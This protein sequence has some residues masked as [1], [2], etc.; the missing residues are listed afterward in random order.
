MFVEVSVNV[1]VNGAVPEMGVPV[2]EAIG[3]IV[4]EMTVNPL[5]SVPVWVSGLVTTTFHC[6]RVFPVKSNV[7]YILVA[8][9]NV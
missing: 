8:E 3:A 5:V 1:T 7:Q 4:P 9:T 6:P 2:K